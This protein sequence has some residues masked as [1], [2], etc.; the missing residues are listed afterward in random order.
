MTK[1]M[2]TKLI[3]K[4]GAGIRNG[5]DSEHGIMDAEQTEFLRAVETYQR[6]NGKRFLR[7]TEYMD[8]LKT[9][10]WRKTHG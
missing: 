3:R 6:V 4:R 10:G 1:A 8:I 9:L 2:E 7:V 5:P